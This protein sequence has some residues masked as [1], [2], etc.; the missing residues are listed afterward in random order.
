MIYWS[1]FMLFIVLTQEIIV[2]VKTK[3]N[4]PEIK[5]VFQ[6]YLILIDLED[7]PH[8]DSLILLNTFL[9]KFLLFLW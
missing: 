1:H 9:S 5:L 3:V 2:P 7:V 6:S 8:F 4:S